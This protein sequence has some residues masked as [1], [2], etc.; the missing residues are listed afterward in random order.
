MKSVMNLLN[1]HHVNKS[2]FYNEKG[3]QNALDLKNRTHH[4][5]ITNF[6]LFVAINNLLPKS[7]S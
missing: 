1:I 5:K 4:P 7:N 6:Y 3:M 2:I